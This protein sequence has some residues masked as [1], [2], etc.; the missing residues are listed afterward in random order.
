MSRAPP[1]PS[2]RTGVPHAIASTGTMPKSSTPG[3]SRA[4]HRRYMSRSTSSEA[5]PRNV[6]SGPAM[7]SRCS[8][9]RPSPNTTRRQL[10]RCAARMA[11][12]ARL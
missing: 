2:A 5:A 12:S 3:I 8:R 11:R 7:S 10:A 1:S 4:R 9:N 6:V